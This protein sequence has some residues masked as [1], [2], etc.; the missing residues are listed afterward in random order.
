MA[1]KTEYKR[2]FNAA[3]YDRIEITVKKGVKSTLQEAATAKGESTT[4]ISKTLSERNTRAIRAK[5]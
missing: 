4:V 1:G 2:Q 5:K 3:N